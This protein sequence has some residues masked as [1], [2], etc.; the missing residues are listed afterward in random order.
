MDLSKALR[1]K[2]PQGTNGVN[3]KNSHETHKDARGKLENMILKAFLKIILVFN[4][5]R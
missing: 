3:I 4:K 1:E 5:F 2:S